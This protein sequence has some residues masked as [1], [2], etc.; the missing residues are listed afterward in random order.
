MAGTTKCVQTLAEKHHGTSLRSS[1][2]TQAECIVI[3]EMT[4][5]DIAIDMKMPQECICPKW[6][7]GLYALLLWE[8][9]A[10]DHAVCQ[11]L[12]FPKGRT[13]CELCDS[14]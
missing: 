10:S 14:K 4:V 5:V 13:P 2:L 1:L 6:V 7:G 11:L 9:Y 8:G 3:L 12:I